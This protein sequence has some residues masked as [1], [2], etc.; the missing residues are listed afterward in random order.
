M[1]ARPPARFLPALQFHDVR[2]LFCALREKGSAMT[3][4]AEG[5][6]LD[7]R[8]LRRQLFQHD[9]RCTYCQRELTSL[10]RSTLDHIIPRSRG[11][12][13]TTANLTLVCKACNQAKGCRLPA[14][15]VLWALRVAAVGMAAEGG[16]A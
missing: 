11:G 14:D 10:R 9:P 13:D 3:T 8:K 4:T 15:V 6:N 12:Q 5:T 7:R 2:V 1:S 16:A